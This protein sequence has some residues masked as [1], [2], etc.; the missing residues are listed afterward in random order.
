M[1][2]EFLNDKFKVHIVYMKFDGMKVVGKVEEDG[3]DE[4]EANRGRRAGRVLF[5]TQQSTYFWF[6]STRPLPPRKTIF[7][8]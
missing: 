7:T 1:Y 3:G 5:K 2:D 4:R 6:Y 8:D